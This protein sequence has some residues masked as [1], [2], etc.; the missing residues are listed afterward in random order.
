VE[1]E[2][3]AQTFR[4]QGL[5][6]V[7]IS[8]DQPAVIR[9]FTDR[10]G[11]FSYP[12]LAD[13]E[14]E[15]IGAFGIRNSNFAEGT[16]GYG[17]AYPGTYVVDAEG[18][19]IKKFFEQMHRQR[20]TADTVLLETFGVG[21]GKRIEVRTA[22]L[23]LAA[24]ASQ[25]EVR[26][27]N[28]ILLSV[29]IA[30]PAG[31]HLYAP[32]AESYRPVALELVENP[33]LEVGDTELPAPES[34]YLEAIGERVPVFRDQ[35]TLRREVTVSPRLRSPALRID[36]VLRYQVCSEKICFPPAEQPLGFELEVVQHDTER[37]PEA[38]RRE[39]QKGR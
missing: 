34:L 9:S 11:G 26:P 25:D 24:F 39:N 33:M 5:G 29:D 7:A 30:L 35:V 27:G 21:G 1:L 13:P 28:R 38:L 18:R 17:M 15:I 20:Y 32:G 10:K 4:D 22:Q 36:A 8:Y 14:S 16:Q 3:S 19:V 12:L 2:R 37:V 6:V 23:A 31:M